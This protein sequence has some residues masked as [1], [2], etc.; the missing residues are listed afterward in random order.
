MN[1]TQP[2]TSLVAA[3]DSIEINDLQIAITI[4][5]PDAERARP[6]TIHLTASLFLRPATLAQAA[7][8]DDVKAT[9]DYACV[10]DTIISIAQSRPRRLLETLAEEICATLFTAY[11]LIQAITLRLTK[12]ILPHTR[13][14]T[15]Q[16]HRVRP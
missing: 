13:N 9:V 4:G 7:L 12:F 6:Q 8:T 14:I 15:L 11:P 3:L 1:Q 16:I 2:S 10:C 5:V